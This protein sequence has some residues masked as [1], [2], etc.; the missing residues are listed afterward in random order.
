VRY[1]DYTQV[2]RKIAWR[3][4]R[5]FNAVHLFDDLM[6]AAFCGVADA[7][8]RIAKGKVKHDN[9]TGYIFCYVHRY[10]REEIRRSSAIHVPQK[11]KASLTI[12]PLKYDAPTDDPNFDLCDLNDELDAAINGDKMLRMIVD[13]RIEGRTDAEIGDLLGM[14]RLSVQRARKRLLKDWRK[15]NV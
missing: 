8:D 3:Y 13:F 12:T 4:A 15:I 10:V 7:R 6:G 5:S 1:K 9:H 2:C 14:S 11:S